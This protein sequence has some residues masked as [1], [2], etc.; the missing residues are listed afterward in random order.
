MS[1]IGERAGLGTAIA[2]GIDGL[3]AQPCEAPK[4]SEVLNQFETMDKCLA[5]LQDAVDSL[6][7]RTMPVRL[8]HNTKVPADNPTTEFV[9]SSIEHAI[10]D[11]Y[12]RIDGMAD[13]LQAVLRELRI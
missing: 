1:Y 10:A 11:R 4:T 8:S 7:R 13:Q 6:D 12:R 5:R 9:A 3:Y 2:K